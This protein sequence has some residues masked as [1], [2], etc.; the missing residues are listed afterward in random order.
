[1]RTMLAFRIWKNGENYFVCLLSTIHKKILRR[2]VILGMIMNSYKKLSKALILQISTVVTLLLLCV[3]FLLFFYEERISLSFYL[4]YSVL[5]MFSVDIS[6]SI[7]L[8]IC[9]LQVSNQK[10]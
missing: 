9:F 4:L 10:L 6:I 8:Y 5:F 1:M 3:F 2:I 7:H